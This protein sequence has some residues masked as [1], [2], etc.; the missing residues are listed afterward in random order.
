MSPER[1]YLVGTYTMGHE[2]IYSK[3]IEEGMRRAGYLRITIRVRYIGEGDSGEDPDGT[4]RAQSV[5]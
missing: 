2:I 4:F 5:L 3:S 1:T